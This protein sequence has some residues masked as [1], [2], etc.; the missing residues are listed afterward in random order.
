MTFG[1]GKRTLK[2]VD[3]D[4]C[5]WGRWVNVALGAKNLHMPVSGGLRIH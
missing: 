1:L 3:Q 4:N 5:G 2:R